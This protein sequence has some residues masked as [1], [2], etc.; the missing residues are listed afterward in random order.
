MNSAVASVYSTVEG[1]EP[2]AP[3]DAAAASL[4]RSEARMLIFFDPLLA[5]STLSIL[6][7]SVRGVPAG[8]GFR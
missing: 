8:I 2:A 3:S 7:S 5:V 1:D 6:A 4:P